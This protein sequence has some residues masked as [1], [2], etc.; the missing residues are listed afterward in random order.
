M[1]CSTFTPGALGTWSGNI[2]VV[3]RGDTQFAH[4]VLVGID[5]TR[6]CRK[7]LVMVERVV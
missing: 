2:Y 4:Y 3:I 5:Y 6:F 7:N 1:R